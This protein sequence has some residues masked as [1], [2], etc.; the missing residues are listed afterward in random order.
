MGRA[1][2][3]PIASTLV[4]ALLLAACTTQVAGQPAATG[5][6]PASPSSVTTKPVE[7]VLV[8]L[9]AADYE[10]GPSSLEPTPVWQCF[11]RLSG[12]VSH[13]ITLQERPDGSTGGMIVNV[14]PTETDG[15][16]LTKQAIDEVISGMLAKTLDEPQL[17]AVQGWV[18]QDATPD[19]T[20]EGLALTY[21]PTFGKGGKF[22]MVAPDVKALTI[23]DATAAI[24]TTMPKV[25]I[26]SIKAFAEANDM[27]CE[28]S[29]SKSTSCAQKPLYFRSINASPVIGGDLSKGTSLATFRFRTPDRAEAVELFGKFAAVISPDGAK[30]VSA[31][32]SRKLGKPGE[33]NTAAPERVTFTLEISDGDGAGRG[34]EYQIGAA[35]SLF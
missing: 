22:E 14:S 6:D 15:E 19:A 33:H 3:I 27:T 2:A 12:G 5:S 8:A 31:W 4:A 20:V 29:E 26:S 9:R 32:I 16:G 17:G 23:F 21:A 11:A 10:C 25:Q 28:D 13:T 30:D 34:V 24:T 1:R 35:P 7:S 18:R